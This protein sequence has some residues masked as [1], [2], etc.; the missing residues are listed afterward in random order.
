MAKGRAEGVLVAALE[1]GHAAAVKVIDGS[2]LAT[3]AIAL[4]VLQAMGC[5]VGA[6]AE[7]EQVEV[8]GGGVPVGRIAT[9]LP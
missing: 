2:P 4:G 7:F 3:T 1:S 9:R 6:A 5:E 8:L